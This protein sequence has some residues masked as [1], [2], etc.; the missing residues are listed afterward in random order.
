MS[1]ISTKQHRFARAPPPFAQV[2]ISYSHVIAR[3]LGQQRDRE[4]KCLVFF[5]PK[6]ERSDVYLRQIETMMLLKRFTQKNDDILK[7][8]EALT[9]F[10]PSETLFGMISAR[11]NLN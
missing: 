4:R 6:R 8:L 9:F 1:R 5:S 3:V 2:L 7:R 10:L 11:L